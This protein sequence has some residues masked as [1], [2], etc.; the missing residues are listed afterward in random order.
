M[1]T[2]VHIVSFYVV[3][4]K[5]AQH[6]SR[7]LPKII[8]CVVTMRDVRLVCYEND[9]VTFLAIG[10]TGANH[11]I[12]TMELVYSV[13]VAYICIDNAIAIHKFSRSGQVYLTPISR[14]AR[15]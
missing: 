9:S 2:I 1:P 7:K 11:F 10:L 3:L 15:A 12:N 6:P 13:D 5:L 8:F 14:C 4:R